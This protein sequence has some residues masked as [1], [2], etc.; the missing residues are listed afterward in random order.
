MDRFSFL[1]IGLGGVGREHMRNQ[2]GLFFI[3]G[4]AQMN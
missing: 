1:D 3:T 4:L 2:V